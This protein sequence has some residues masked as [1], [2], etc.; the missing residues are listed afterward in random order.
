MRLSRGVVCL[1]GWSLT[2]HVYTPGWVELTDSY[3]LDLRQVQAGSAVWKEHRQCGA[4]Q[5]AQRSQTR[6]ERSERTAT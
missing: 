4:R 1:G 2:V 6:S 5:D 3:L